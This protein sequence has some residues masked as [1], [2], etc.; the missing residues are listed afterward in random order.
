MRGSSG[1][2]MGCG[3]LT[4]RGGVILV[5]MPPSR[6][7][8]HILLNSVLDAL[9]VTRQVIFKMHVSKGCSQAGSGIPPSRTRRQVCVKV[10]NLD[11]KRPI[12]AVWCR[13]VSHNGVI[14]PDLIKTFSLTVSQPSRATCCSI[15][16][17]EYN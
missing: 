14:G 10:S 13:Q 11:R 17:K 6:F 12:T 3:F 2:T 7:N 5:F 4:R 9:A 1:N 8:L 16:T 15:T